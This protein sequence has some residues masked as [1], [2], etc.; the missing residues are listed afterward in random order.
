MPCCMISTPDRLN[1]GMAEAGVTAI[2]SGPAY[3]EFRQR[4]SSDN[5]PE[6]C[7]SCSIYLG[8]F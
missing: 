6:V 3:E 2:W 8:T 1:F 7:R 5:P 4:L